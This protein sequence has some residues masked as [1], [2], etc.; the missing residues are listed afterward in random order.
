[1]RMK[2]VLCATAIVVLASS[3]ARYGEARYGANYRDRH[4]EHYS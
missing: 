4:P 2:P 3:C 1:M